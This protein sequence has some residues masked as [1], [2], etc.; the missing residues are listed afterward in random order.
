MLVKVVVVVKW[1]LC[2]GVVFSEEVVFAKQVVGFS[3][4]LGSD[5]GGRSWAP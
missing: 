5:E 3:P 4:G 1:W 2:V